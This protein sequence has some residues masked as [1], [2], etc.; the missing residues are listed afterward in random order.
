M[1]NEEVFTKIFDN[2]IFE[3]WRCKDCVR[4]GCLTPCGACDWWDKEYTGS[5]FEKKKPSFK[6]FISQPMKG[7]TDEEIMQERA[8]IMA[9]WTNKSVEFIDSF[10]YE[11]GKNFTDSLGKSISLMSDADLVVFAPGWENARGCRIEHQVARDY[12]IQV[13]YY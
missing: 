11:P 2:S 6:I 8:D 9:K 13:S 1:T 3:D 4:K 5:G 10:F 7:R 12:G